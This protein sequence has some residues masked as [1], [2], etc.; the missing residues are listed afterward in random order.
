MKKRY[1]QLFYRN[2]QNP[3]FSADIISDEVIKLI[4][5]KS[6]VDVGC[7]LGEFL[8]SFQKRGVEKVLGVDGSWVNK[9]E[10]KIEKKFFLEA[11]L[12]KALPVK[13][14]FDLAIS[15]EVAE[16]L[17]EKKAGFFIKKITE[18]APVV[19][20]SAAIPY[21]GGTGHINEQWPEYW[22]ALFEKEGYVTIDCLRNKIWSNK[23]VSFVY[24]Q[25][26]LLFVEKKFLKKNRRLKKVYKE[27][28]NNVL[29]V[30]HP[31][32]YLLKAKISEPVFKL[33]PQKMPISIKKK[34]YKILKIY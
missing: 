19:L 33:F 21:Q 31:N 16:H 14:K 13:E 12:E 10:L 26:S 28:K 3:S 27:N 7:G 1:S 23:K 9:E 24:A 22:A 4:Q 29:S 32:L 2:R 34:L 30:V 17:S 6:V 5:P 11:N 8:R 18:L 15:L 20:F 25:N